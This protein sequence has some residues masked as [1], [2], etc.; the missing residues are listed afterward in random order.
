MADGLADQDTS[1][2]AVRACIVKKRCNNL[3]TRLLLGSLPTGEID[4]NHARITLPWL[5]QC[6]ALGRG[7]GGYA[8]DRHAVLDTRDPSDPRLLRAALMTGTYLGSVVFTAI[9]HHITAILRHRYN[10]HRR[11][12]SMPPTIATGNS[13]PSGVAPV[14]VI[15]NSLGRSSLA[16]H[17]WA[18]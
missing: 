6:F 3:Y 16:T 13:S 18:R 15:C 12:H 1:I 7:L 10:E 17:I 5:A 8:R 2:L 11:T 4:C 9:S 14:I